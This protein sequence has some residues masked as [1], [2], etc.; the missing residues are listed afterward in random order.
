MQGSQQQE[1]RA[2]HR[3]RV[4]Q[5]G[6]LREQGLRRQ[7]RSPR[8]RQR[9]KEEDGAPAE[10]GQA[11]LRSVRRTQLVTGVGHRPRSK[12]PHWPRWEVARRLSWRLEPTNIES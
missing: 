2:C 4:F 10:D 7:T 11:A 3:D 5:R 1:E 12:R 8:Q 6:W 9:R